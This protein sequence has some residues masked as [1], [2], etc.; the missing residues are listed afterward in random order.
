MLVLKPR[1]RGNWRKTYLVVHDT[2][3]LP[4][5]TVKPGDLVPLGGVV[6]RVWK[7]LP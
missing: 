6:F 4:T 7:V 3:H 5:L 1:G 2:W